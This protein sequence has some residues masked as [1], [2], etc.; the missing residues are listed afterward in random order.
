M[1]RR[2]ACLCMLFVFSEGGNSSG[3]MDV[4]LVFK[5]LLYISFVRSLQDEV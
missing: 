2:V 3:R 4:A 5:N 1:G